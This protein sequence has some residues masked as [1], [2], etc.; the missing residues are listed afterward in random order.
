MARY[1]LIKGNFF[2]RYADHPRQGPQPDGD[3]I[4]FHADD[5]ALVRDLP[6]LSGRGPNVNARG[7]IPVRYEGIDALETHFE[8]AHQQL[9][10]ANAAR[11]ENL[12]LLGFTNVVF[13]DD[14]PNNV[15]SADH[16]SMPGYVIANGIESNGRMLGLVY[17]GTT[18]SPDGDNIFVDPALLDQSVNARLVAAGLAYMEPYDTMPM[19]LIEH[20]RDVIAQARQA[21]AGLFAAESVNIT[22]SATIADLAG[23]QGLVMWPKLFRRLAAYFSQGHAGLAEFDGW[24]RDDPVGRDDS[25]RLPNGEKANMHDAYSVTGNSLKLNFNPEDLLIA[26]DPAPVPA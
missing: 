20:F 12:R 8:G 22:R 10:F 23:L 4:T 21:N 25:L 9:Q 26:P 11:G 6:R 3:T 19:E 15:Q 1:T 16:D 17:S 5:I 14:L 24:I 2:I 18:T 13:F 7:N